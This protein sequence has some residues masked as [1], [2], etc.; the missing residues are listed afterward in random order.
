MV[1]VIAA[2]AYFVLGSDDE[3]EGTN[4]VVIGIVN[5]A[6]VLDPVVDGFKSGMTDLGYIEGENITYIYEGPVGDIS[7]LD[8]TV[9]GLVDADVD[10]ILSVSTPATQA[11]QRVTAGSDLPVVF[12]PLTDPVGAGVVDSIEQPGANIT[13]VTFGIQEVKRMEWLLR[14]APDAKRIFV[15][16]NNEDNSA[17]I[18]FEGVQAMSDTFDIEIVPE[19][20]HNDEEILSVVGSIPDDVDAIYLLPDSLVMS[21]VDAFSAAAIEKQLPTSAPSIPAVESGV[22]IAFSMEFEAA[23]AQAATLGNRILNGAAPS[24]LP[25]ETTEFFLAVNLVTAEAIGVEISDDILAQAD[26]I[27]R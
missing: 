25:V 12:A 5:L 26:T 27:V 16:Y 9:Q 11:A 4:D 22:L 8:A 15:P 14:V 18:A 19:T 6:P 10:M 13:G 20:A 21:Q 24:D 1:I 23:G 17:R 3:D 7:Q 2:A